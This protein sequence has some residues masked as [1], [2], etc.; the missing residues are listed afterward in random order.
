MRWVSTGIGVTP[1]IDSTI[2]TPIVKF[3]TKWL[4]MMSTCAQSALLILASSPRRSEKSQ[5]R[6]EGEIL[7]G[8]F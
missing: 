2:G 7:I 6:M 8:Q 3:G 5:L 1:T 4:S